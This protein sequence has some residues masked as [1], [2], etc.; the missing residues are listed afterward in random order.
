VAASSSAF[1][2]Y[3]SGILSSTSGCGTAIN[4]AVLLVGYGTASNGI[5]FWII[6]N[7]YGTSWG[8]AGYVRIQRDTVAGGAGVC[9]VQQYL[10]YPKV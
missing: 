1:R 8:E 6:K 10:V 3:K 5:P 7:S 9:G 2:Y 4:H